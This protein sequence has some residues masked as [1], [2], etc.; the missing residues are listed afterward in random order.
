MHLLHPLFVALRTHNLWGTER[1][2]ER[3]RERKRERKIKKRK[4]KRLQ[5]CLLGRQTIIN[6]S[7]VCPL[8]F[9]FS[10]E[11]PC[12]FCCIS[13]VFF[14][15]Y[16]RFSSSS[17]SSSCFFSSPAYL[18]VGHKMAAVAEQ[19]DVGTEIPCVTRRAGR[20]FWCCQQQC[21]G[22]HCLACGRRK[23]LVT[24]P[25][26]LEHRKARPF[27][28]CVC[29]CVCVCVSIHLYETKERKDK[30]RKTRGCGRGGGEEE[31]R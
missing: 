4:K 17:S 8:A 20:Q 3:E 31:W 26:L 2:R 6:C 12:L 25:A 28:V 11:T 16:S 7:S 30:G 22:V 15:S 9:L 29:V 5:V 18:F 14:S 13:V 27:D 10:A 24:A 23:Q 21:L 1:E 19:V